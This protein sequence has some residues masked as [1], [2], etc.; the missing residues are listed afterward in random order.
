MDPDQPSI[1]SRD[2]DSRIVVQLAA[3]YDFDLLGGPDK[4]ICCIHGKT[5]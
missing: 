3:F 4:C 1:S 5:V 2:Y